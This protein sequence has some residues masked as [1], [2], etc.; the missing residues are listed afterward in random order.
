[1]AG[2]GNGG[3]HSPH[4]QEERRE[5]GGAGVPHP[6]PEDLPCGDL[7]LSTQAFEEHSTSKLQYLVPHPQ[8]LPLKCLQRRE[9]PGPKKVAIPRGKQVSNSLTGANLLPVTSLDFL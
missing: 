8:S 9:L 1:M 2:V 3:T 7:A 4:G 6:R 5:T